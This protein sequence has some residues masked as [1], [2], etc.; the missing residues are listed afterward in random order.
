MRKTVNVTL[1]AL[2]AMA[3]LPALAQDY[4]GF[5]PAQHPYALVQTVSPDSYKA[6]SLEDRQ[7]YVSGVVDME[8]YLM[9]KAFAPISDCVKTSSV[10]QL[11]EMVDHGLASMPP[12]AVGPMPQNVHNALDVECRKRAAG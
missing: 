12:V 2:A 4:K 7:H 11:T 3:A 8:S 1:I 10:A 6:M 5:Q 9:P